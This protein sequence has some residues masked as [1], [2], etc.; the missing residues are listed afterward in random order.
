M[1]ADVFARDI[2]NI[3]LEGIR[4]ELIAYM[5]SEDRNAT[6]KSK[7]S[8]Q[9]VNVSDNT[10]QL[11]GAS[12]IDRTF[13]GTPAGEMPALGNMIEWCNARGIPRKYAWIIAKNIFENGSKLWQQK[14]NI[15]DEIITIEKINIF[16]EQ[17][18]KIYTVQI[19][20]EIEKL[21]NAA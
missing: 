7:A 10:G 12:W 2:I 9:V 13:K 20:S 1:L 6:G 16:I 21:F 19:T 4:E 14:R 3:F 17:I 15:F 8:L 11:I 18:S 5:D